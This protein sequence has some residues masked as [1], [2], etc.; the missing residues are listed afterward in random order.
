MSQGYGTMIGPTKK[1]ALMPSIGEQ[2]G[3]GRYCCTNCSWSVTLDDASDRLPPCG[4][5]GKGQQT[6]YRFC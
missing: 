4:S 2:P 1:E 3:V 5:C 6:E